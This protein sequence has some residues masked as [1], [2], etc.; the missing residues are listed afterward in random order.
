MVLGLCLVGRNFSFSATPVETEGAMKREA[1][2]N[3]MDGALLI[4]F[5]L[6]GPAVGALISLS[7]LLGVFAGLFA[8]LTRK[9]LMNSVES[10][11]HFLKI[12]V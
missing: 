8:V 1:V 10:A 9:S 12:L 6:A 2:L 11:L 7:W 5:L 4:M 3:A